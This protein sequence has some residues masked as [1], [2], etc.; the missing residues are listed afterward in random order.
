MPGRDGH[1][2]GE[3][4]G[5]R[6]RTGPPNSAP[7][8][9]PARPRRPPASPS[10]TP[11]AGRRAPGPG[12]ATCCCGSA[13]SSAL[14]APTPPARLRPGSGLRGAGPWLHPAG[15]RRTSAPSAR[16]AAVSHADTR[17]ANGRRRPLWVPPGCRRPGHTKWRT[18]GAPPAP[19]AAARAPEPPV[20]AEGARPGGE[21][22]AAAAGPRGGLRKAGRGTGLPSPRAMDAP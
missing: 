13:R 21:R 8:T 14:G 17:K 4:A 9:T 15:G 7:E 5:P 12:P 2:A 22:T 16:R 11:A 20:R 19:A 6:P 10:V 3:R 1:R 18:G